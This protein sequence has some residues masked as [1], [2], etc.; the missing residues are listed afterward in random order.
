MADHIVIPPSQ[1][2]TTHLSALWT[3]QRHGTATG[4]RVGG[5]GDGACRR[6]APPPINVPGGAVAAAI[7]WDATSATMAQW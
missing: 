2:P 5:Q 7:G 1:H 4:S 3:K 6:G